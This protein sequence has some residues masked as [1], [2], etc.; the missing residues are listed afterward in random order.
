M[1]N[2]TPSSP[3]ETVGPAIYRVR[4]TDR[5]VERVL[6]LK[7]YRRAF[8]PLGPWMGLAAPDDSPLLLH[9]VGV[10]EIYALHVELP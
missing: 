10:E 5:M 1:G 7:G 8:G 9:D 3:H 6:S 2:I 4:V